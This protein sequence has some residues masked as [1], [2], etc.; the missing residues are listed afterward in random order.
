MPLLIQ[1]YIGWNTVPFFICCEWSNQISPPLCI[2][3]IIRMKQGIQKCPQNGEQLLTP[4][5]PRPHWTPRPRHR[6]WGQAVDP[7]ELYFSYVPGLTNEETKETSGGCKAALQH[8]CGFAIQQLEKVQ[9]LLARGQKMLNLLFVSLV[10][11]DIEKPE[12]VQCAITG[13]LGPAGAIFLT[14]YTLLNR[15]HTVGSPTNGYFVP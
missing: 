2:F 9:T 3:K 5:P 10:C 1:R 4:P 13:C 14:S 12:N 15:L 6:G 7:P 11:I 8:L